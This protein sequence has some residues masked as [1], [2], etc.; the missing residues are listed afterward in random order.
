MP[1]S[2]SSQP[3]SGPAF[4][5]RIRSR[6]L[7]RRPGLTA[8][9]SG[10]SPSARAGECLLAGIPPQA[11]VQSPSADRGSIPTPPGQ[12]ALGGAASATLLRSA[13]GSADRRGWLSELSPDRSFGWGPS[14]RTVW[15]SLPSVPLLYQQGYRKSAGQFKTGQIT[16]GPPVLRYPEQAGP[17]ERPRLTCAAAATSSPAAR[18]PAGP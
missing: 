14:R 16:G 6:L 13:D 10:S 9:L 18:R 7:G 3:A 17:W 1:K 11:A 5:L 15:V 8:G 2:R 4:R 12:S